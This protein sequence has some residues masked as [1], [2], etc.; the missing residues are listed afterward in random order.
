MA[1]CSRHV[2][3]FCPQE[4]SWL[5][6]LRSQFRLNL[7]SLVYGLTVKGRIQGCIHIITLELFLREENLNV[8]NHCWETMRCYLNF[9]CLTQFR[10]GA[11]GT[12]WE[13]L[14]FPAREHLPEKCCGWRRWRKS[15][16]PKP[17][18]NTQYQNREEEGNGR[19]YLVPQDSILL[20]NMEVLFPLPQCSC[21]ENGDDKMPS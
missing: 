1:R 8:P 6:L 19:K 14:P 9:N 17:N 13:A 16:K 7:A 20:E 5:A 3:S 4:R 21:L 10:Q 15:P 12:I 2:G 11:F 18:V